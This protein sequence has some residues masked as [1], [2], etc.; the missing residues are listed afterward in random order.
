[1]S[2]YQEFLKRKTRVNVP[3]GIQ[4]VHELNPN[5]FDF[6]KDEDVI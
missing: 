4:N 6:Q 1:M 3:T 5:M 2:D